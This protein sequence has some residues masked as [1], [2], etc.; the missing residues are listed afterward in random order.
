MLAAHLG[1]A[2]AQTAIT[3]NLGTK[4][5]SIDGF[6]FSQ[7]F[8]RASEFQQLNSTT[9][10]K[11]G[12]DLLFDT[13]VGAGMTIIRNRIGS[14][15]TGDSIEPD[16]PGSP[17]ATATYVWDDYDAGQVWLSQQ[18]MSY[19]VNTIY[20][21][22]W[23]AP[24]FMKTNGIESDG[25][26]LCG[27]TGHTCDSGDWRQAYANFLVEYVQLYKQ[28]GISITHLGFL[29]E[30]DYSV[31][32]SSMLITTS[33]P[34]EVTSFVPTLYATLQAANLTSQV[35]IACCDTI[36]WLDAKTVTAALAAANSITPY[37]GL[38][39]SHMYGSDPTTPIS[40]TLTDL[41]PVWMTEGA[42]L[43]DAWCTTW[44][45]SGGL[46]EG[47]TWA[48]K[49]ATGILSANLSAYIYWEGL[50]INQPQASSYLVA[51]LDGATATPSGRLWA[52]AMWSRFI[53]PGAVRLGATGTISSVQV[54]AF[55]NTDGSV[56]VVF[57]NSGSSAQSAAVSFSGF[58]PSEASAWLTDNS[59]SVNSTSASLSGGVVTVSLPSYSVVTHLIFWFEHDN[60]G[61][62]ELRELVWTVWWY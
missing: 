41:P 53:R 59:N 17:N 26:Y 51:V 43:N 33:D 13:T 31:G 58:A 11:Q 50:E 55:E 7:A 36:S 57:T 60:I 44:Y 20:A 12:L 27:T 46:C 21:D 18:A 16:S 29:N 37:I 56:V 25:G 22:A 6:G 4:Y 62:N 52:F 47:M 30:P 19:G 40:T 14:G 39:T 34:V 42:D 35:T 3:V 45:S 38:L 5:Q 1:V 28:A 8:G 49:I 61:G 10:Q 48:N 24:G 15:S 2:V 9:A 23:S 54:G 32:Y